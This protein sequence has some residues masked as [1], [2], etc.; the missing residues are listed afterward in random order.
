M[1][2]FRMFAFRGWRL[3]SDQTHLAP[4]GGLLLM[5]AVLCLSGCG[6]SDG[7]TLV[8]VSGTI[9]LDGKPLAGASVSFQRTG[10]DT[11][12]GPGSGAVTDASGKYELKTAEANSQM[13]AVVGQHVVRI[14]GVQDQRAA[15]DDTAHPMAK[16]PVPPRYRDRGLNFDVPKDGTDKANFELTSQ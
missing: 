10:G 15:D 6:S 13:G 5:L 7:Y 1:R 14:T 2:Q 3:V 8:P 16:D 4:C 11:T 9:T 12:V